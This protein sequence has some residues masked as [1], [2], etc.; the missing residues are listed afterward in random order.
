MAGGSTE[1]PRNCT[2]TDKMKANWIMKKQEK[3]LE[4]MQSG[5]LTPLLPIEEGSE[6]DEEEKPES[7]THLQLPELTVEEEKD[8]RN[9]HLLF[10]N[11]YRGPSIITQWFPSIVNR[12]FT[13]ESAISR[14]STLDNYLHEAQVRRDIRLHGKRGEKLNVDL[15]SYELVFLLFQISLMIRVII[16]KSSTI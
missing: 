3:Q 16:L 10:P 12:P 15:V 11:R 6:E 14:T 2:D 9:N 1:F 5:Y 13:S 8:L 7:P 4:R